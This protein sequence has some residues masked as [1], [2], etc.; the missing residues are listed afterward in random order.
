MLPDEKDSATGIPL[1]SL[2]GRKNKP[3]KEDLA[4]VDIMIYDVQD[5]G[6]RYYTNI[7]ALSRLNGGLCRK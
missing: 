5:V 6:V 4:D 1:I 3:T 7:N 2:Y